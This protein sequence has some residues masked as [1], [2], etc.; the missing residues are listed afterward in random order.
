MAK[1]VLTVSSPLGDNVWVPTVDAVCV[2]M[3]T[4]EAA[5][6]PTSGG[7]P[8]LATQGLSVLVPTSHIWAR[9][10]RGVN[11]SPFCIP[12]EPPSCL[13]PSAAGPPDSD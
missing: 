3:L 4:R 2:L 8:P 1:S 11:G 9:G 6:W 7:V 5:S 12:M 10:A 13:A